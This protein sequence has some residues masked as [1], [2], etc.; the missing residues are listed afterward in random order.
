MMDKRKA[1]HPKLKRDQGPQLNT[2]E[3]AFKMEGK[4]ETKQKEKRSFCLYL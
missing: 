4:K 3:F 2:V 1:S